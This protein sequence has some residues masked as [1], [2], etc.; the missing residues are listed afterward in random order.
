V[1]I[2]VPIEETNIYDLTINM[3]ILCIAF[4]G[5]DMAG[6]GTA[7]SR[8]VRKLMSPNHQIERFETKADMRRTEM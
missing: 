4:A 7:A 3:H 2:T 1:T 6:K 5:L 8:P